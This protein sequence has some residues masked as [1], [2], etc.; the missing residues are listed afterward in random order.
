[1]SKWI[2]NLEQYLEG[3]SKL[4]YDKFIGLPDHTKEQIAYRSL[5]CPDCIEE[6]ACKCCGCDLPGKHYVKR[7]CN[8]GVRFP[9][10]MDKEEWKQYKKENNIP[11]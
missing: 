4:F 8:R 3:N 11:L 5:K 9:D 2:K 10:L 6:G 1:M 7:S